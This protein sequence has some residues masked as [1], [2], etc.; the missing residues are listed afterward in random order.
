MIQPRLRTLSHRLLALGLLLIALAVIG[1]CANLPYYAQAVRGHLSLM[2]KRVE[3]EALLADPATDPALR[4]ELSLVLEVRDFAS[5]DLGLPEN[6]SYRSYAQLDRPYVVW[7]VVAAPEYSLAPKQWCFMFV[8]CLAYKGYYK[9]SK[10]RRLAGKLEQRGYE[11]AVGGVAAYSTLGRFDDPF[12]DTMIGYS[13]AR[14]ASIIFHELAHQ[15]L[16]VKGDTAFNE[17]FAS[18]VAEEGVRRWF[19]A[20]ARPAEELAQWRQ[21]EARAREFTRLVLA[22]RARLE[23]VYV[24]SSLDEEQRALAKEQAYD[25]LRSDYATLRDGGW[26]GYSGY[27]AWFDSLNNARLASIA[28]YRRWVPAFAALLHRS[29]GD[30]DAFLAAAEELADRPAEER[31]RTLE[32]LMAVSGQDGQTVWNERQSASGRSARY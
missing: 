28:T 1:G 4:E 26:Q 8:G 14:T 17:A 24:D 27:D 22:G 5:S 2:S 21:R 10:A 32:R 13:A 16:Y 23:S 29:G 18:F 15:Q 30:F 12:L 31:R 19:A 20:A 7:N 9:E 11:V 25:R 6:G 3:I